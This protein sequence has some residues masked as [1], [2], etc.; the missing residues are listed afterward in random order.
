MTYRPTKKFTATIAGIGALALALSACSSSTT[1]T[2]SSTSAATSAAA[3]GG[4][5]GSG[6]AA[7]AGDF[8]TQIKAL[9]PG[10]MTGKTVDYYTTV[11]TPEDQIWKTSFKPFED[12]TGAKVQWESSKSFETDIKVRIDSGNPPD[13]AAFPQPG[14]LASIVSSSGAVKKPPQAV[15]DNVDK[16]YSTQE[17]DYGTVNGI[18]FAPPLDANVKSFVWYSPKAFAA[19]GYT[20]PTTFD[21]L[22]ALSDKIAATGKKPWCAGIGSGDATG[23][24]ATDWLEDFVLRQ[25]GPD[26]YEQWVSHKIPFNDPKIASALAAVGKYLKNPQYVNG[27]FGDVATIASTAFGDGGLPILKGDCFMHRQANFYESFWPKGTDVSENGDVYAFYLP[28]MSDQFGKPILGGGTFAGAFN[29]KPEV[30]AFQ[31]YVTTPAWS[32]AYAAAGT[33]ITGNKALDPSVIK[34][35]IAK[36]SYAILQDPKAVFAFD[37]SD[38]M[39]SEVGS[40]AE[41]KQLTAWIAQNQ[42]DA[43][44][45]NNI[46]AAWPAS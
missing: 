20:V 2:S 15:A 31:Y 6:G 35:P 21:E 30:Q 10:D 12:C 5:T 42:D 32:N 39:P 18:F 45:L 25:S 38:R 36:L 16:Y 23:W 9:W 41:W 11:S 43:T 8:C 1:T 22:T 29:D 40:G 46:E 37:A 44:T 13:I 14:L 17:K 4:A 7:P 28:T 3:S 34:S 24:P 26:V 27:G 19:A 33:N